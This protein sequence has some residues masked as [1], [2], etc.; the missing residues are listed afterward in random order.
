MEI[1]WNLSCSRLKTG[2]IVDQISSRWKKP[3]PDAVKCGLR[4][5]SVLKTDAYLP[6]WVREI[7]KTDSYAFWIVLMRITEDNY[8]NRNTTLT[9]TYS[10]YT[11]ALFCA[12]FI[13]LCVYCTG[14]YTTLLESVSL[15][16][17]CT[18]PFPKK[19]FVRTPELWNSVRSFVTTDWIGAVHICSSP[20]RTRNTL[21]FPTYPIYLRFCMEYR[22][23]IEFG[24]SRLVSAPYMPYGTR[25]D[26]IHALLCSAPIDQ[27]LLSSPRISID[28][29]DLSKH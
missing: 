1:P 25:Q 18:L 24:L 14:R 5:K 10:T 19:V 7:T 4:A 15:K 26:D 27:P 20:P 8:T 16:F 11:F 13:W 6:T 9:D 29:I 28:F 3:L 22:P 12:V 2:R 17:S 21:P 23:N